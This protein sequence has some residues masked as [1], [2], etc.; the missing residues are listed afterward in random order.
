MVSSGGPHPELLL[1]W[2]PRRRVDIR[3][4]TCYHALVIRTVVERG[5]HPLVDT[6]LAAEAPGAR[7]GFRIAAGR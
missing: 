1:L 6:A 4:P 5:R 2:P 3:L 7:V